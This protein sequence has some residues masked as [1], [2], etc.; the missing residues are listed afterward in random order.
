[1]RRQQV[2]MDMS[3]QVEGAEGSTMALIKAIDFD[4]AQFTLELLP[5]ERL[6]YESRVEHKRNDWLLGRAAAKQA[7]Q[8]RMT[9]QK[10]SVLD[11]VIEIRSEGKLPRC[12]IDGTVAEDFVLS[13]SHTKNKYGVAVVASAHQYTS[14]G[15]DI[16]TFRDM[17]EEVVR[18]MTTDSEFQIWG[19]AINAQKNRI[20]TTLWSLKEAYAKSL[21]TGLS[22]HPQTINVAA[23]LQ[24]GGHYKTDDILVKWM[25]AT[26]DSM[27][28]V[29]YLLK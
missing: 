6:L 27:L 19:N 15:I 16:E 29:V 8:E 10:K 20:A 5:A 9:A 12:Y 22:V 17:S 3:V 4:Y 14:V 7:L 1:M 26:D 25:Q 11:T 21:G 2:D 23:F 24:S 13:I 28:A 18:A